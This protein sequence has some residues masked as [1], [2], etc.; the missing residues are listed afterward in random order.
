MNRRAVR[1]SAVLLSA[2]LFAV[3]LA[4]CGGGGSGGTRMYE[5]FTVGWDADTQTMSVA[6]AV[7]PRYVEGVYVRLTSVNM[8]WTDSTKKL[9]GTVILQNI[10]S[11][12]VLGTPQASIIS[13]NPSDQSITDD[14]PWNHG[15]AMGPTAWNAQVW[16]FTDPNAVDFSFTVRVS[17]TI[18]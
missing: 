5:D 13:Y 2:C 12:V 15:V 1:C 3:G 9:V 16:T 4:G 6:R 18:L 8:S 17:F 10:H 7:E 14:G 11:S